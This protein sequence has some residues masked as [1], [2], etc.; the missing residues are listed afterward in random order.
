MIHLL[1]D[2]RV[3]DLSQNLAGPTCTRILA[4]LGADVIK[5]EP[6][7]GDPARA[8]GPPFWGGESPLFLVG[9]RNKR[10]IQ[11]DL[12]TDGGMKVVRK[13]IEGADVFVQSLRAGAIERLGLSY[14]NV[15]QIQSDVIYLSVTAYGSEGPMSDQP[16]YD[17][18]MQA[19]SGLMSIT[20]HPET[21]PARTGA[22]VVDLGTGCW[23]ALGVLSALRHRDRTGEGC[24]IEAPLLDTALAQVSY[25]LIGHLA[26]GEVPGPGGT[27]ISM[28]APYQAFPTSDGRLMIAAG[29]DATF[30]RLCK[31]LSLDALA[32]DPELSTNAGRVA[33]KTRLV[34][35]VSAVTETFTTAE[36]R[37]RLDRHAVPSGPI[38]D[39]AE[40]L[41][42]SQVVARG[43]IAEAHHPEIDGYRTIGTPLLWDGERTAYRRPPPTTGQ[44]TDEIL[45]ELGLD[46]PG[47]GGS[48]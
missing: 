23:A 9:N 34:E 18:L 1:D 6:P 45:A 11:L 48:G 33:N 29:N 47:T 38:N 31:A 4:D 10:S 7:G 35:A 8:W 30:G 13:L 32:E 17:P 25:H 15:R 26:T 24:H 2:I 43:L 21:G 28:I 39:V 37:V 16:G 3:V 5:V 14:E 12:K 42:D 19:H 44:H 36:L 22:S 27:G 40:A 41:A 20:G 46:P